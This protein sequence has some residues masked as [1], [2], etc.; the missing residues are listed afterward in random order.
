MECATGLI[1]SISS[2]HEHHTEIA[3]RGGQ[4]LSIVSIRRLLQD[5]LLPESGSLTVLWN[6]FVC[7]TNHAGDLG[8][9]ASGFNQLGLEC[10]ISTVQVK[11]VPVKT[12][13][14]L[15]E[16]GAERGQSRLIEKALVAYANEQSVDDFLGLRE[17]LLGTIPLPVA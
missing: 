4:F 16:R 8:K 9:S 14:V 12:L 7:G 1:E 3:E 6:G 2:R 11:I 10:A 13:S 17:R 15:K 5:E